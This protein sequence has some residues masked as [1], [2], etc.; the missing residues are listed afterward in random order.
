M[1]QKRF[2]SLLVIPAL[3]LFVIGCEKEKKEVI[4][5]AVIRPVKVKRVQIATQDSSRNTFSG[6]SREVREAILSFRVPGVLQKLNYQEGQKIRKGKIAAVLDDRDYNTQVRGLENQVLGLQAKLEQLQKGARP[7]DLRILESKLKSARA[8]EQSAK[9]AVN[10]AKSALDTAKQEFKR[11]NQLYAKQATSKSTLDRAKTSMEQQKALHEQSLNQLEQAKQTIQ[12]T[13]K[14][15]E[16]AR[17]GGRKEDIDAQK[18][19]LRSLQ[20][21]LA[22]AR[23]SLKDT[24]L[25]FPFN[26][27]ISKKYVS[28]YEQV[29]AGNPIYSIIDIR[30]I[31]IRISVPENLISYIAKGEEVD[32][33]ILNFPKLKIAGKIT[34]I[35]ITADPKTLTYPVFVTISNSKYRIRPGMTANVTLEIRRDETGYPTIPLHS[36][37]QDKVSKEKYIWIFNK[38]QGVTEKRLITLGSLNNEEIEVVSGVQDGEYVITAGVHRISAGMKVRILE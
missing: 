17:K 36:I 11:A 25:R 1:N 5:E 2:F 19:N 34:K 21:N 10:S 23:D 6:T 31:E 24:K 12:T 27:M 26:G 9:S 20:A 8:A 7:E 38:E 37:I 32:V 28:N 3:L 15:L 35:G 33:R 30:R 22:Q 4:Q 29:G 16:K 13:Q 18:A 14:E